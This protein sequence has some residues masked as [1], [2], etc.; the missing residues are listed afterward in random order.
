MKLDE[1]KIILKHPELMGYGKKRFAY[2]F[3]WLLA[4]R[5]AWDQQLTQCTEPT[6]IVVDCPYIEYNDKLGFIFFGTGKRDAY[7]MLDEMPDEDKQADDW[8]YQKKIPGIT[9]M[10]GRQY[11]DLAWML[12]VPG[13]TERQRQLVEQ[14]RMELA[15]ARG[16]V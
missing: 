13:L 16:E 4:A 14:L 6:K 12:T 7:I 15:N 5:N 3:K 8:C 1:I 10:G 9:G 2:R 11:A